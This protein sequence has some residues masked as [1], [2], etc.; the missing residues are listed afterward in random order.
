MWTHTQYFCLFCFLMAG[1]FHFRLR[2]IIGNPVSIVA[3]PQNWEDLNQK[4][5]V[6]AK[7]TWWTG[8][9]GQSC[10]AAQPIQKQSSLQE[11]CNPG[12]LGEWR[13]VRQGRGCTA[14]PVCSVL[15]EGSALCSL[16]EG[17][18]SR[19]DEESMQKTKATQRQRKS[20]ATTQKTWM[21]SK[22]KIF[23]F[24]QRIQNQHAYPAA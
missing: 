19:S 1:P 13:M 9:L 20:K 21:K 14:S 5:F 3:P 17:G 8:W 11:L 23:H 7:L 4:M 10:R 6:V 16:A 2:V 12:D 15:P 22:W 24:N 18:Q